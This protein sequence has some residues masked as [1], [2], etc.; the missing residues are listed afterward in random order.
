MPNSGALLEIITGN[1][2]RRPFLIDNVNW[3]IT[4]LSLIERLILTPVDKPEAGEKVV[5]DADQVRWR[6]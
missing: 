5:S 6:E 1:F 3:A 2:G 4:A